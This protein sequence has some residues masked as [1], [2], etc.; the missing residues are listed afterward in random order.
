MGFINYGP[1]RL[2]MVKSLILGWISMPVITIKL[3]D[4]IVI[5]Q[6][7]INQ[8]FKADVKSG[9]TIDFEDEARE[10]IK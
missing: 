1:F 7:S 10:V 8:Q 3:N 4:Y 2:P 5:W 9:L 6:K